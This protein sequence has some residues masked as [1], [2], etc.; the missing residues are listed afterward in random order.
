[1]G[2]QAPHAHGHHHYLPAMGN[3]RLLPLYDTFTW[4]LGV[5][6]A[7]RRLAEQAAIGP[8][9][10][11]LSSLMFHH[12]DED[13]KRSALAEVKRVL[14]PGGSLHLMD[15]GGHPHGPIAR[16]L[17]RRIARL[18]PNSGDAILEQMRVA[19]LT[20]ATEVGQRRGFV[21]VRATR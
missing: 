9:D 4:L 13:T 2:E 15:F 18:H 14:K 21:Y 12:L 1:M 7:H 3:D 17:H 10:R 16:L 6:A 8:G 19:G 5:P 11:V 20:G